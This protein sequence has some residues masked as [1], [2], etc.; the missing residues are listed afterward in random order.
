[1]KV[2][3]FQL[4]W[5]A[6]M[7][8][9][10]SAAPVR[11]NYTVEDWRQARARLLAY[12][13]PDYPEILR[14]VHYTGS[15]IFRIYFDPPGEVS[16]IRVLRSTGHRELDIETLK[17]LGHW[18]AKPGHQWELDLPITFMMAHSQS[19]SPIYKSSRH[20]PIDRW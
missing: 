9:S 11:Q 17:G 19:W 13:K 6:L 16:G 10:S 7:A 1:M 20:S 8:I 15:G 4:V 12:P 18:R 2:T 5:I 3:L 14:R